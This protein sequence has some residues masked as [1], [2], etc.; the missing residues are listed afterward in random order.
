MQSGSPDSGAGN[1]ADSQV[2]EL[3]STLP[4]AEKG[5][6]VKRH[7]SDSA[8]EMYYINAFYTSPQILGVPL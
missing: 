1:E 6:R 7:I 4:A 2:P 3:H 5:R 8:G